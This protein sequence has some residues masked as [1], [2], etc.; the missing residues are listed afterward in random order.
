MCVHTC[1]YIMYTLRKCKR[2]RGN[3]ATDNA[4]SGALWVVAAIV[5]FLFA[6]MW[7]AEAPTLL[8]AAVAW[9]QTL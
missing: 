3:G 4:V 6:C 9:P 7:I 1:T 2:S 5:D 8:C